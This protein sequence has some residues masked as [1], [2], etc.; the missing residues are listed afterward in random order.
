MLH[1][2]VSLAVGNTCL[3]LL[4]GSHYILSGFILKHN[5]PLAQCDSS[6]FLSCSWQALSL[7][8]KTLT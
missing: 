6:T 7:A 8:K 3:V 5:T 4:L 1:A 2:R